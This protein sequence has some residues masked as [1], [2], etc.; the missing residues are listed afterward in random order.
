MSHQVSLNNYLNSILGKRLE[1]L[2]LACEM[3]MFN[4]GDYALHSLCLTRIIHEQDIL[5][6]TLDYQSWDGEVDTNNDEHYF[7]EKFK[8]KIVGGIVTSVKVSPLY[9]VEI[10]MDNGIRI[11][12]FI[13]NGYHHFEDEEEQWV[14]FKAGDHS[15]PYITVCNKTV[16]I[17]EKR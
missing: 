15:Y 8:D 4:F 12:L 3:M 10:I 17:A 13:Q 1:S 9:D 2:N 7:V 5:V 6:T 11:E 16:D 14:F